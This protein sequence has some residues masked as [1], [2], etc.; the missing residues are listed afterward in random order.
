MTRRLFLIPVLIFLCSACLANPSWKKAK[1]SPAL[2]W[3]DGED[4]FSWDGSVIDGFADGEGKIHFFSGGRKTSILR[5]SLV[6]GVAEK[7]FVL[8]GES[9]DKYAGEGKGS[10]KNF[11]PH[12]KG[13]LVKA[14]GNT[15]AG[16][17]KNGKVDGHAL[18]AV[19]GEIIYRGNFRKNEFCGNGELYKNGR[20]VYSGKFDKGKRN[21]D[22]TE[23]HDGLTVSGNFRN[24]RKDGLFFISGGGIL[25]EVR[26][27][28]GKADLDNV[29]VRYPSGVEWFGKVDSLMNP[30]GAG[31]VSY[32]SGGTY[33][34]EVEDNMRS[35]FGKF[36]S[37]GVSYEGNWDDDRCSGYGEASFGGGAS[38]SGSWK[39]NAFDGFG[40]L[41][42]GKVRYSGSWKDG[43]KSGFG[44]LFI[45]SLRYDGEFAFD[46]LNGSGVMEYPNGD[47]Y[48]GN[49][50]D[51]RREGYGEY[52]WENG[53][54]YFGGWEDDIQNGEGKILFSSG[55]AY[56]GGVT[57]GRLD[58][59][60][61]YSF[62]SGG[63]YE[64][65]FKD[66]YRDGIGSYFFADGN[67]YEGEFRN[68]K[69][70]GTGKF[71][72]S[73]GSFYDGGFIGGRISGKGSLYIPD[74]DGVAII[75]SRF[76][77]GEKIP[78]R[79]SIVF[80]N[81]DEF[82]GILKDGKPT[83]D[84]KWRR[85]GERSFSVASYDF[86]K[87]HEE[88]INNVVSCTQLVLAG[89]SVAGD[90][91]SV[92]VCVPCPPVAAVA[93][94]VSKIADIA[95]AAIS[96]ASLI[97]GTG[98]MLRETS[99]AA[100]MHDDEEVSRLRKEYVKEQVWNAADLVMTF[101]SMAFKSARAAKDA[102]K[103]SDV[104]PGIRK[105]VKNSN[106]IPDAARRAG[107]GTSL[108]RG[109]VEI[110]YGK[111]GRTLV[112]EYG[113]EAAWLLFKYG[114]NAV[115][116]LTKGGDMALKVARR[117]GEK[118]LRAVLLEGEDALKILSKNMDKIDDV[119][120]IIARHGKEGIGVISLFSGNSRA[121]FEGYARHGDEIVS[122]VGTLGKKDREAVA[123]LVSVHGDEIFDVLGKIK[124]PKEI[125]RAV[126]YIELC[127][128]EG[129]LS[130][131]KLGR[132]PADVRIRSIEVAGKSG[133]LNLSRL[134][135]KV[136]EIRSKGSI[137]LS[138]KEIEWIKKDPKVNFRATVR[139]KTGEKRFC[140]G[141][142]EFF[143]RLSDGNSAQVRELMEVAEIKKTVNHAIRGGGGV[144][145]WLMTKNYVDFLTNAK[146]GKDGGLI[147]LALT[148]LVQD[149]KSVAFRNGGT[150]FDK[151]NS[152]KFHEGLSKVIESSPD[153]K[154]LLLNVRGYAEKSLTAKSFEEFMEIFERCFGRIM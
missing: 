53:D 66:N 117:G 109:S 102:S 127:G 25:R 2:I 154:S 121:F 30:V 39:D 122:L 112:S 1:D 144:H 19:G 54:A 120:E 124:N 65:E 78:E 55:D 5:C 142:Q 50:S 88:T 35:G 76:W 23:Y 100:S 72:F 147:S 115:Y 93:L 61:I 31:K 42:A 138:K 3:L 28:D 77:D 89:I 99:D 69:M 153:A 82:T 68:G 114:E 101:G 15:Y 87:E 91:V 152:G 146:W 7:Y 104:Y 136:S 85:A 129:L 84:G 44:T 37:P 60:G 92:V 24:D 134:S 108:V 149:T 63:R 133:K 11:V 103:A 145:E 22:G 113:D 96:G 141:F 26:F 13:V 41:D 57:D 36:V 90:V 126:K 73:D 132:V 33:D 118:A 64:G 110:A 14:N 94:A 143:I 38:Y 70:D 111:V 51:S 43:K 105:A 128:K 9:S 74:G 81:G 27:R 97:V 18:R 49:W 79:A 40:V 140:D 46:R 16:N 45:G 116:S 10:G 34:G 12:G 20:L 98:V 106:L 150:H 119:S 151:M 52:F 32:D 56:E 123:R 29:R 17:F 48:S 6:F 86:Y 83:A 58:G 148:E 21:G 47:I 71:F 135:K 75:T 67:S 59:F 62:A 131:K 107:A 130:V 137:S 8:L 80:P 4:E 139:A 125:C 95:N